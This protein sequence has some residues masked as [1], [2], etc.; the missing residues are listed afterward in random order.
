MSLTFTCFSIIGELEARSTAAHIATNGV[1]AGLSAG[2]SLLVTLRQ[3]T[4]IHIY[5]THIMTL[6]TFVSLLVTLRQ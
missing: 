6:T 5:K 4:L 2:V 3:Q 1:G